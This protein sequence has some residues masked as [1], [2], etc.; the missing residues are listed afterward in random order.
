MIY[1]S[2]DVLSLSVLVSYMNLSSL[3]QYIKRILEDRYVI[4]NSP[5]SYRY[6]IL[7][8]ILQAC[9]EENRSALIEHCQ[10]KLDYLQT[11]TH[12]ASQKI[13]DI[14]DSNL[15]EGLSSVEEVSNR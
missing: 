1:N 6:T 14:H 2:S 7:Q 3:E 4:C 11:M 13:I 15:L 12:L 5:P 9:D 8:T 10:S